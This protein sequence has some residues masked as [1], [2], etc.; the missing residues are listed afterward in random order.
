VFDAR[1]YVAYWL[2]VQK[3]FSDPSRSPAKG[4]SSVSIRIPIEQVV[5]D[6]TLDYMRAQKQSVMKRFLQVKHDE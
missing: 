6:A 1:A 2:Y 4:A 5:D 3:Y